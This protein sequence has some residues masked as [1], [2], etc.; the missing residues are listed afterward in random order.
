MYSDTNG[1]YIPYIV[2]T[3]RYTVTGADTKEKKGDNMKRMLGDLSVA[4][5]VTLSL[6]ALVFVGGLVGL[7][8]YK[9]FAPKF[10]DARREVFENTRSY[11]QAKVQELAKYKLEYETTQDEGAKKALA[12]VIRHKFADY[13]DSRLPYGL[14]TFL[15][16]VRGY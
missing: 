5:I 15:K 1:T 11:N 13:N 2:H 16:E 14:K 9:F 6:L 7:G 12:N 4:A 10:E 3:I 8:Y